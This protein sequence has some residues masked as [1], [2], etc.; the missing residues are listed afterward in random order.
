MPGGRTHSRLALAWSL[1]YGTFVTCH[2]WIAAPGTL[3]SSFL[4]LLEAQEAGAVSK[5]KGQRLDANRVTFRFA[6]AKGPQRRKFALWNNR[7]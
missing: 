2:P 3:L 1:P 4:A 5:A 7:N 6:L